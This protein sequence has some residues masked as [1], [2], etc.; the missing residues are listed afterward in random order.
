MNEWHNRKSKKNPAK[1]CLQDFIFAWL[2]NHQ[3]HTGVPPEEI[4]ELPST[5]S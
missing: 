1:Q 2:V 5:L 3:R 4:I